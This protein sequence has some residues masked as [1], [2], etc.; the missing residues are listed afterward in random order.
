MRKLK[1]LISANVTICFI[2]LL[3]S[4]ALAGDTVINRRME[5][6]RPDLRHRIHR[7][8]PIICNGPDPAVTALQV[9]EGVTTRNGRRVGILS[10][11][12]TLKNIG[13]KDYTSRRGQ[14]SFSIQVKD[15]SIS[16]PRSIHIVKSKDFPV[17]RKGASITLRGTYEIPYFIEWG[18]R[19]P[20]YGECRASLII[21]GTISYDP[22]I[23]MDANPHNDDCNLK[24]NT[25]QKEVKFMVSCPW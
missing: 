25:K 19:T 2:L 6:L 3:F 1:K 12:S 11:T 20:R 24:N 4:L 5:N 23:F 10:I 16:G 14:Q 9:N 8:I 15:P 13:T 18:H 22:D 7:P 21:Y 17:L